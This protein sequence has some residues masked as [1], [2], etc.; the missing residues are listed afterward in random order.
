MLQSE[1]PVGR[2]F[3]GWSNLRD[4]INSPA[5]SGVSEAGFNLIVSRLDADATELLAIPCQTPRDFILKVIAV[6]DWGGV[7]L[8]DETRAPELWA[9]ARA[10]VNWA[11]RI[12]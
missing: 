7:A 12:I 11:Y 10:L 1:T 6:T 3:L 9:E 4:Q 2:A 5:F 8:P